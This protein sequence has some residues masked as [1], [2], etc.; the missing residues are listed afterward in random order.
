MVYDGVP[1]EAKAL[2]KYGYPTN[3]IKLISSFH[4]GMSTEL[5]ELLESEINESDALWHLQSCHG[6]VEEFVFWNG[7]S[8]LYNADRHLVGSRSKKHI[9]G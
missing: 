2:E 9:T 3:M 8:I 4:D 5:K 7:V 1:R 6:N